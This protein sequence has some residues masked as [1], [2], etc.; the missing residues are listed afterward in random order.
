MIA[1]TATA[2]TS[3]ELLPPLAH[4]PPSNSAAKSSAS[5]SASA[6]FDMSHFDRTLVVIVHF[7][8]VVAE[9]MRHCSP[10]QAF[11][12][13]KLVYALVKLNPKS[14][15]RSTLL[16]LASSRDSSAVIKNH[17]LSSFPSADVLRLLLECGADANALDADNNSPLH[18]AA[19]NRTQ[20]TASAIANA[21]AAAPPLQ[22]DVAAIRAG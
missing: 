13:K 4:S 18:L 15:R 3:P 6:T 8:V 21:V 22:P 5:A 10:E 14:S 7:L 2:K 1:D 19:A 11:K 12:L 9:S 16:H 20:A 17:T